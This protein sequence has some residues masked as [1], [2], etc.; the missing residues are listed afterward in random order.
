METPKT[1]TAEEIIAMVR[2][3][4]QTWHGS[5]QPVVKVALEHLIMRVDPDA[6]LK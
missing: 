3:E 6:T 4:C 2:D 1:Y 5:Y